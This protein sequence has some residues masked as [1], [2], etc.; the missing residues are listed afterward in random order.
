M[1]DALSDSAAGHLLARAVA[2]DAEALGHI[3]EQVRPRVVV[4]AAGRLSARLRGEV[5]PE[6]VAQEVLLAVHRDFAGFCDGSYDDFLRWVFT[7][8][9]HRVADLA[10]RSEAEKRRLPTPQSFS[11]TSPSGAMSR[12]EEIA[13][14]FRALDRLAP[15]DREV[16]VLRKVEERPVAELA[17]L[18]GISE[19]AVRVR[20]C[21]ALGALRAALDGGAASGA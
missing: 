9:R 14:L 5:Q 16:L 10:D 19:N 1:R 2:G 17:A 7:I 13:R 11:Q 3:L 21:R 6:D 4:W 8:A 18:W 20:C 15:D 12:R